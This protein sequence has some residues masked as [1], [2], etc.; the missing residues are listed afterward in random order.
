[1][2][3]RRKTAIAVLVLVLIMAHV[4]IYRAY[5][6]RQKPQVDPGDLA[7]FEQ[8]RAK[9]PE[10][11]P[12]AG[13]A[14]TTDQPVLLRAHYSSAD[15]GR[16]EKVLEIALQDDSEGTY[17]FEMEHL[18]RLV[19]VDEGSGEALFEST[20]R[21]VKSMV[22]YPNGLVGTNVGGARMTRRFTRSPLRV[23][24]TLAST[25]RVSGLDL[26]QREFVISLTT[27]PNEAVLVGDRWVSEATVPA[28]APK[29]VRQQPPRIDAQLL[30]L[31]DYN[32][33]QAALITRC[34]NC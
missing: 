30:G 22:Q 8:L 14:A 29:R 3:N 10:P 6:N 34:R 28:D 11:S 18:A 19:S 26:K 1:M 7:S 21:S 13:A 20:S 12:A 33:R 17:I 24:S 23:E 25:F 27:L 9:Y 15:I 16:T 31:V 2:T 32:A 4:V 5:V